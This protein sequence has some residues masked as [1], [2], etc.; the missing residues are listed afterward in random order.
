[1]GERDLALQKREVGGS[2]PMQVDTFGGRLE[3]V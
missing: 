2:E 3:M 1:M